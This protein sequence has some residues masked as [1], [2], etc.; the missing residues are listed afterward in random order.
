MLYCRRPIIAVASVFYKKA[1]SYLCGNAAV[2]QDT[3]LRDETAMAG[4]GSIQSWLH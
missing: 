4:Q 1:A 2:D 3:E